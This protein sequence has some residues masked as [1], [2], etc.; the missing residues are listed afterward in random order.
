MV[1]SEPK[2][3]SCPSEARLPKLSSRSEGSNPSARL[4][5]TS[6]TSSASLVKPTPESPYKTSEFYIIRVSI[7][8]SGPETEGVIMYKSIM[9]GN[10]ER[11]RE[12]IRNAMM[13]HGLEGSPDNYNLSQLLPDKELMIPANA[14]VY[15]AISTQ[16]DL[17][18]VL[19]EKQEDANVSLHES[20][21]DASLM[22]TPKSGLRKGSRD[23]SKAR[24]KLM[25][26]HL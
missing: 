11:T 9:I 10:H 8:A 3:S 16:H 4:S 23:A 24:R 25:G 19:R 26:L 15:Y 14:N 2:P 12:V 13:K 17:N 22:S 20:T 6:S 18:F 1:S 7:E 21:L 5:K